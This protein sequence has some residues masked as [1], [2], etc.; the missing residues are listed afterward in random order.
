MDAPGLELV[1]GDLVRSMEETCWMSAAKRHNGSTGA[2]GSNHFIYN[3]PVD[4]KV[5]HLQIYPVLYGKTNATCKAER[6]NLCSVL[7]S[8]CRV[9]G[10]S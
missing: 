10:V 8:L 5:L 6:V 2:L 4:H 3:S 1:G 7:G 9:Y